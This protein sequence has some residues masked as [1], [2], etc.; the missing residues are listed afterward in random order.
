[1]APIHDTALG[2]LQKDPQLYKQAVTTFTLNYAAEDNK[3]WLRMA[4]QAPLRFFSSLAH[5]PEPMTI[6]WDSG[7]IASITLNKQDFVDGVKK[8][9]ASIKLIGLAKHLRIEG[10]GKVAWNVLDHNG[11]LCS[12][13]I[14][15]YYIPGSLTRLLSTTSLLQTYPNKSILIEPHQL[16]LSG[17]PGWPNRAPVTVCIDPTNNLPT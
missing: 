4:L 3:T 7:A 9:P 1:M 13:C 16:K 2:S 8:I 12:L 14:P 17:V 5:N 11:N 10:V 15:T 6:I